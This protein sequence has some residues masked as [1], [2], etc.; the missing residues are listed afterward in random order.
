MQ[1]PPCN[2]EENIKSLFNDLAHFIIV[3]PRLP[4]TNKQFVKAETLNINTDQSRQEILQIISAKAGD[5]EVAL[6]SLYAYR[7]MDKTDWRPFIKAA[8][9]RNPV[10]LAGLKGKTTDAVFHLISVC[11]DSIYEHSVSYS[12]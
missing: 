12:R 9:E 8:L 11:N 4:E 1:R 5:N 7:Q 10:S 2:N 3:R 6:L